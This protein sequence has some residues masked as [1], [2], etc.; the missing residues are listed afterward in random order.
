MF[1]C[2][3][4]LLFLGTFLEKVLIKKHYIWLLSPQLCLDSDLVLR[5]ERELHWAKYLIKK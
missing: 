3:H 2:S 1:S 5:T 4:I